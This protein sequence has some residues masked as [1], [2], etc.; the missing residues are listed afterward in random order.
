M[1]IDST[2]EVTHP[3][4]FICPLSLDLMTDPLVSI[5]GHH[6]QKEAVLGW[7]NQGNSTCPLTR[8]LLTLG[9]LF[10]DRSLQSNI[11]EWM[12]QNGLA[13]RH[14]NEHEDAERRVVGLGCVL[15]PSKQQLSTHRS[16]GK[17]DSSLGAD[18]F[19]F[20]IA[21]HNLLYRLV[22]IYLYC[23]IYFHR[24]P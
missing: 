19:D 12:L 5:C 13:V 20:F 4:N 6:C 10:S 18:I 14:N 8:E 7:L 3:E 21:D 22:I 24:Y 1:M 2:T 15:A 16:Q 9:M 11:K 23:Q 17:L